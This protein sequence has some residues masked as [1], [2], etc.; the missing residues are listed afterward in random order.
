MHRVTT[1]AHQP[2]PPITL[3]ERQQPIVTNMGKQQALPP[4]QQTISVEQ[5]QR[6]EIDME[7]LSVHLPL[8]QIIWV[9]PQ[10]PI[11]TVMGTQQERIGQAQTT[12]ATPTPV[13]LILTET[14]EAHLPPQL[15]TSAT[16]RL[17]IATETDTLKVLLHLPQIILAI[18]THNSAATTP[19]QPSGLGNNH[20]APESIQNSAFGGIY[21]DCFPLHFLSIQITF[22]IH[23]P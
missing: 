7:I 22:T 8:Q 14:P 13:T 3:E 2:L 6:I 17:L 16:P 11:E 12:W 18:A 9:T 5:R 20:N 23:E 21:I 1:L 4:H 19:T 15:T 10:Q